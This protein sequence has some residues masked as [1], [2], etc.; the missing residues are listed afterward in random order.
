MTS[1]YPRQYKA[2]SDMATKKK[3]SSSKKKVSSSKKK[4]SSRIEAQIQLLQRQSGDIIDE[5]FTVAS[6]CFQHFPVRRI[7]LNQIQQQSQHSE[8]L[9]ETMAEL[10]RLFEEAGNFAK[11][12]V[13]WL[14]K[15][16]LVVEQY[17]TAFDDTQFS[18]QE[19]RIVLN[20]ILHH[21]METSIR[22]ASRLNMPGTDNGI[23][24]NCL[25]L[26]L[27]MVW[28]AILFKNNWTSTGHSTNY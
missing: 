21:L 22:Y 28:V 8:I 2:V 12:Q 17:G 18:S 16:C 4:V 26:V 5:T 27:L 10:I 19:A 13:N 7:L 15:C 25:Y 11:L 23:E 24:G 14:Q 9:D 6:A 1:F 20:T 3:V